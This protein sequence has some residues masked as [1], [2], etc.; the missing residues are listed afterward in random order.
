MPA[1]R[2]LIGMGALGFVGLPAV[3]ATGL[4]Q[5]HRDS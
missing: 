1:A 2:P 3:L 5:Q 4:I